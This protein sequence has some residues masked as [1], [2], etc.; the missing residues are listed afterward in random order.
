MAAA[1]L[2]GIVFSATITDNDLVSVMFYGF[3]SAGSNFP[4]TYRPDKPFTHF[5]PPLGAVAAVYRDQEHLYARIA[6]TNSV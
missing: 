5:S 1:S 3:H 6:R 2:Y 4:G